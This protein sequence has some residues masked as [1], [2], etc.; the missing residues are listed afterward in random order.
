MDE[1]FE[2]IK[3]KK[4]LRIFA[5]VFLVIF[6][7]LIHLIPLMPGSWIIVIGLEILGVR[8]LLQ[9]RLKERFKNSK[10]FHKIWDAKNKP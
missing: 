1:I 8:L 4:K 10:F 2:Q 5:G 3:N 9:D 7:L 6:G